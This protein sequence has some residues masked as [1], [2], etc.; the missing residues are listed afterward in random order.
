VELIISILLFVV[1]TIV[2]VLFWRRSV[3]VTHERNNLQNLLVTRAGEL[4]AGSGQV[5][6]A[7]QEE[8]ART[9][10]LCNTI[11]QGDFETRILH[12]QKD[13]PLANM[14][15]A[16]NE[17]VDRTDAFM[18]EAEASMTH[19]SQQKYYRRILTKD[20]QGSFRR[21]ADAINMCTSSFRERG[22]EFHK[23]IEHFERD[24]GSLSGSIFQTSEKLQV[25]ADT[26][27]SNAG[28]TN[29]QVEMVSNAAQNATGSVQTVASAAE[30]LSASI[31]EIG[32]QVQHSL[33]NAETARETANSGNAKIQGLAKAV[34]S[35]GEVVKLIED[36][37]S[38]TNLLALNAT[39]EAAR[40]GEA[41]KGFAVVANE[42]KNLATQTARATEEI[43]QQILDVQEA[44]GDAVQSMDT[45][46]TS[47]DDINNAVRTIATAIEEQG[48]ATQEISISVVSAADST[49]SVSDNILSVKSAAEETSDTSL[50]VLN[51]ANSLQDQ[52]KKLEHNVN[53]FL[54]EARR[55]I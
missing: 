42:V 50:S 52:T 48:A 3:K 11:A 41:G 2:A 54:A 17:L 31:Q 55:S 36:I 24:V 1:P 18:R 10:A 5:D 8:I 32:R 22:E 46:N 38:Q 4:S 37:A 15:W 28:S 6:P 13:G 27:S 34:N 45:I 47:I 26:L 25:S 14:Q 35:I 29:N 49:Q 23:I 51:E 12:I 30:E 19:V 21:T 9:T 53:N 7:T 39:I 16:I 44:S 20:M 33:S 43:G 40:A